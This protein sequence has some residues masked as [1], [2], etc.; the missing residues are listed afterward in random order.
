MTSMNV[1][2]L[3]VTLESVIIAKS[4]TIVVKKKKTLL[5]MTVLFQF[6]LYKNFL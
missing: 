3:A 6:L 5:S 1:Q 2:K 4:R